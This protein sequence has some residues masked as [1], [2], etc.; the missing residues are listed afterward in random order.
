MSNLQSVYAFNETLL[1][2]EE[3]MSTFGAV[4]V[5]QYAPKRML[6]AVANQRRSVIIAFSFFF[7][8]LLN[9]FSDFMLPLF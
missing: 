9:T 5:K 1:Q 4:D 6:V 3:K 8:F 7:L 2:V